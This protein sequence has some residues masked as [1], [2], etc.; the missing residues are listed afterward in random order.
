MKLVNSSSL[1]MHLT[2]ESTDDIDAVVDD[3]RGEVAPRPQHGGDHS[4]HARVAV[5]AFNCNTRPDF[6][7]MGVRI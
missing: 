2:I 1:P 5:V 6:S 7:L 3:P 4:P